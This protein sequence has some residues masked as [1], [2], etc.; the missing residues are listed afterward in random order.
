MFFLIFQ[1]IQAQNKMF[2][3]FMFFF[4]FFYPISIFLYL[5]NC[6]NLW[7]AKDADRQ[8]FFIIINS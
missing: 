1:L 2:A 3:S 7:Q 8:F 4:Y 5:L 6:M